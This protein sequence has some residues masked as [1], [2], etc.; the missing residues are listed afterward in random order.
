MKIHANARTCPNSRKLLVKCIEEEGW[1]LMRS[2]RKWAGSLEGRRRRRS[3]GSLF[4]TQANSALHT[5]FDGRG[6]RR[7][8]QTADDR[9]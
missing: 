7:T 3:V 2:A 4:S 9:G 5:G 1:T 8:A 6:D